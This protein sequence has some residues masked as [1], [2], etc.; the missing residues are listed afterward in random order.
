MIKTHQE[1]HRKDK[2]LGLNLEAIRPYKKYL[3][4]INIMVMWIIEGCTTTISQTLYYY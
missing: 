2:S 3:E 4:L 1:S